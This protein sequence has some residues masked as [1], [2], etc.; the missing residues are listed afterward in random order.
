MFLEEFPHT[1]TVERKAVT[2][3]HTAYPPKEVTKISSE[4]MKAFMDTPTT[5]Q[6]ADFKAIGVELSS[7]LFVPYGADIRRTDIIIYDDVKYKL[8][9]DLEDQGR[10]HEIYRVPL[11]R[12]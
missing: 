3:D 10:Q 2:V 4:M 7:M 8:N 1:I 11:I 5:S 6:L 9:G 12:A